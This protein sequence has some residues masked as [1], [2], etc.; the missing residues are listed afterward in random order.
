MKISV[1]ARL[2]EGA[3]AFI[4]GVCVAKKASADGA[5]EQRVERLLLDLL[6]VRR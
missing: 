4:D 3:K 6:D 5:L 2:A 1:D